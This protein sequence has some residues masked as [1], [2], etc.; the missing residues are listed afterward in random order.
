MD[1][2]KNRAGEKFGALHDAALS[3]ANNGKNKLDSVVQQTAEA[4]AKI[5]EVIQDIWQNEL[6]LEG[7][8][9]AVA[10]G[11]EAAKRIREGAPPLSPV[12]LYNELVT[13]LKDRVWRRSIFIFACGAVLGGSA[14]IVVGLRAANRGPA[15][16]HA[17]ALQTQP[18]QSVI[19]VEDAV[20]HGAGPGEVLVRVQAF[21]V[22]SADRGVLRG[23]AS[24]LRS[25]VTRSHV[26]VGR[27]FAG[28]VLD[29][30]HGVTQFEMGDEVWGCL[31]EW[32][33]GAAT[34]LL[35]VRSTRIS[36]RPRTLGADS[37]ASLPWGGSLALYAL[38]RIGYSPDTC[39]GKRVLVAGAAS[40]EGCALVQLLSVWGA[41][42]TAAA[43]RHTRNTLRNLGASEFIE[44]E[45]SNEHVA[46]SWLV[47]EQHVGRSGP[48]DGALAC[49]GAPPDRPPH[50]TLLKAT[51]P[52]SAVV[53]LRPRA[54]VTDRLITPLWIMY[55][56]TVYT[57]NVLRWITGSGWHWDWLENDHQMSNGLD[58]LRQLVESGQLAPVLDKVYFPQDF[59]AALAHACSDE[60]V[61]TTVI[62]FP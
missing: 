4:L 23:R 55:S 37:A 1:E 13:L 47:V 28:V 19:L 35:A 9:R 44:L 10:W 57:F 24:A 32:S 43:P 39:K 31:S 58:T 14:G 56:A 62:R 20:S 54:L 41:R 45:G 12:V 6:V 17:R 38:D 16:P 49:T 46:A 29:V 3:A 21:S 61:G 25:L 33:G 42:P 30:G 8:E 60:A 53:E 18:D 15:G 22:C 7:R 40:S 5:R 2:L 48:W 50:Y 36:K 27:G 59:E 52:R 11:R 51:A 34:E 26:T